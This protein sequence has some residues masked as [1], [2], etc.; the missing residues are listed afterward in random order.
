[1]DEIITIDW[2]MLNNISYRTQL[3]KNL[4]NTLRK[5]NKEVLFS[6]LNDMIFHFV[7]LD[8]LIKQEH[9]V[10]AL[11]S[12]LIKYEKYFPSTP[13]EKAFND[14]LGIR[15]IVNDYD[16]VDCMEFPDNTKIADMRKGKSNDDGYRAIHVYYQKDHY[17]YPI[18]IQ[19]MTPKDRQFNAW[20][21]IY[22]YKYVNDNSIGQKLK[23][24]YDDG[25]IQTEEDFR[26]EM[27]KLCAI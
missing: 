22:L 16:M 17:H 24:L 5:F 10:K 4:K 15:V 12:C 9:R 2:E 21:H 1:M 27:R 14:I 23:E 20:L 25:T 18:E 8:N 11:H 26:K 7:E 13:V 6:E 3:E 19:F